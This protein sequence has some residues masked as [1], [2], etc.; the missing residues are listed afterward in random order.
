MSK[1][2]TTLRESFKRDLRKLNE[3]LKRR[4]QE[5]IELLKENPYLGR[6]LKGSLKDL[7]RLR[8]GN[9]RV[10]YYTRP[11][12]VILIKVRHRESVRY[13]CAISL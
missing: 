8:I 4:I 13:V 11:C 12:H 1:C 7:Q 10:L 6:P 9:Y 2:R 5:E 3:S